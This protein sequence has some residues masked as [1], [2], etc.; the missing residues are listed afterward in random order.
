MPL[1]EDFEVRNDYCHDERLKR[2]AMDVDLSD[3]RTLNVDILKLFGGDILS[4]G[5]FENVLRTV[6]DLDATIWHHNT[7]I[8]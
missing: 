2:V 4:L 3:I 7:D 5:K 6:D 1:F 8:S